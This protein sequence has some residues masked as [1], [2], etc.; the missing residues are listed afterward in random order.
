M[1]LRGCTGLKK[2]DRKWEKMSRQ[3]E[4]RA[5]ENTNWE[6]KKREWRPGLRKGKKGINQKEEESDGWQRTSKRNRM[7][8]L[9]LQK[10]IRA[11][12]R[13]EDE[14]EEGGAEKG[15]GGTEKELERRWAEE[16]LFGSEGRQGGRGREAD[17]TRS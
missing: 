11:R 12:R 2:M 5:Q 13:G 7:G 4:G 10:K 8:E 3:R 1:I 9:E 14:V 16:K 15:R 6:G 17:R